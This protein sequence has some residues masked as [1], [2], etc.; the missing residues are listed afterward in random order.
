M[1]TEAELHDVQLRNDGSNAATESVD[2]TTA[3]GV[4]GDGDDNS[5]FDSSDNHD[6]QFRVILT[7]IDRHKFTFINPFHCDPPDHRPE[8]HSHQ[9]LTCPATFQ[10]SQPQ[11]LP[12]P[13]PESRVQSS[14]EPNQV[15]D[16]EIISSDEEND[17]PV[18][19]N[20][21]V[22]NPEGGDK[23]MPD[24]S[25]TGRSTLEL[26]DLESEYDAMI[27]REGTERALTTIQAEVDE[28]FQFYDDEFQHSTILF[29]KVFK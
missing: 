1:D 7:R 5:D 25:K 26:I 14:S 8:L 23:G 20:P 11:H 29:N 12:P 13:T 16:M 19:V 18:D 9:R 3:E 10:S 28:L 21:M 17:T 15:I 6:D 22:E 4:V 2:E 24:A 27:E